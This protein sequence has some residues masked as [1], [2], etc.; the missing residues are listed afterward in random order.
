[1]EDIMAAIGKTAHPCSFEIFV[2]GS[3]VGL[4]FLCVT[5]TTTTTVSFVVQKVG[6]DS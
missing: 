6:G 4:V 3:V 1:M 2:T 5:V